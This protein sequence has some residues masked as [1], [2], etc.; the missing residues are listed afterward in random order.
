[1][2]LLVH[3]TCE[4]IVWHLKKTAKAVIPN[5]S[6]GWHRA[7]AKPWSHPCVLCLLH[8]SSVV[9]VGMLVASDVEHYIGMGSQTAC[10][11]GIP[12]PFLCAHGACH[13]LGNVPKGM[14]WPVASAIF[15]WRLMLMIIFATYS[16][17]AR[18]SL[19]SF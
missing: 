5:T 16:L 2:D 4:M 18:L 10:P 6:P 11:Q 1:M 17:Q 7:L 12:W 14:L 19:A 8:G 3:T 13:G 9:V 15:A